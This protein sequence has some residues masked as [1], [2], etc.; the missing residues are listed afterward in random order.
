MQRNFSKKN[1][2]IG[3]QENDEECD[4]SSKVFQNSRNYK[5]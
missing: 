3:V 5:S 2:E 4:Y 1:L